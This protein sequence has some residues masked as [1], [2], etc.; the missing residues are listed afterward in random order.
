[1]YGALVTCSDRNTRLTLII[2][3]VH[4]GV[5]TAYDDVLTLW[6]ST[7]HY[8]GELIAAKCSA[9]FISDQEDCK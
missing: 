8:L 6:A 4:F 3:G 7:S 2:F 1:M 5:V 9:L